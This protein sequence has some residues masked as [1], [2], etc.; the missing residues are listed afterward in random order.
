[1]KKWTLAISICLLLT[2]TAFAGG[3]DGP[4][5]RPTIAEELIELERERL[6][7]DDKTDWVTIIGATG[8]ALAVVIASVFA[9]V[10]M[11]RP[12]KDE[13]D[14]DDKPEDV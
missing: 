12:K 13:C 1:M 10:K 9:G 4:E 2:M 7:H 14:H 3:G 5:P 6:A 8:T 11:L